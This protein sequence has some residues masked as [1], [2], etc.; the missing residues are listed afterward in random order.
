MK[1]TLLG[2]KTGVYI[3]AKTNNA[4]IDYKMA[5]NLSD[6]DLE[7][8]NHIVVVRFQRECRG[9]VLRIVQANGYTPERGMFSNCY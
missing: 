4:Y 1:I 7:G 2:N 3:D 6:V 8:V 5:E 9:E